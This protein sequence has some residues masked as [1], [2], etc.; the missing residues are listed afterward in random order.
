MKNVLTAAF[1]AA[2]FIFPLS[3]TTQ[4]PTQAQDTTATSS[5]IVD[6]T[7]SVVD[8]TSSIVDTIS[9]TVESTSSEATA[10]SSSETA[11]SSSSEVS[12]S[13]PAVVSGGGVI[14]IGSGFTA[15]PSPLTTQIF[16]SSTTLLND[17]IRSTST[18][19]SQHTSAQ[20]QAVRDILDAPLPSFG[21]GAGTIRTGGDVQQFDWLQLATNIALF[22]G[23][24]VILYC[25][26]VVVTFVIAAKAQAK[27][28][29][30][31]MDNFKK[32]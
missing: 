8:T 3:T 4:I 11:T 17:V 24:L 28:S 9:S 27:M 16:I 25:V 19:S 29:D 2:L 31:I 20:K 18:I 26:A 23:A 10:T 22:L 14:V 1:I 5:S 30:K 6:T 12:S 21:K 15:I 32:F 7:S 13:S